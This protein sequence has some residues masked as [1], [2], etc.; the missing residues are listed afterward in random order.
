MS[1]ERLYAIHALCDDKV[2]G[3][4]R[5]LI[6]ENVSRIHDVKI[7]NTLNHEYYFLKLII[8]TTSEGCTKL[9]ELLQENDAILTN[10]YELIFPAYKIRIKGDAEKCMFIQKDI[11]NAF[12]LDG[13]VPLKSEITSN[14]FIIAVCDIILT[15]KD[16]SKCRKF[17]EIMEQCGDLSYTITPME[18][19]EC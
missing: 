11:L 17:L 4:L 9:C 16:P 18:P 10:C 15:N 14:D 12:L 6:A 13:A 8:K 3:K 2:F 5:I 19:Y 7:T 1:I